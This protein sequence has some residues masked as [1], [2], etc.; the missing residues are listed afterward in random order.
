MAFNLSPPDMS[1]RPDWGWKIGL[2][3]DSLD[4]LAE[5]SQAI[6]D[7][8]ITSVFQYS[9]STPSFEIVHGVEREKPDLLFVELARASKPAAE[10]IADVRRGGDS[11]LII[12]VHTVPE[13]AEMISALRAGASEFVCLP[14]KP[15][16]FEALDRIGTLLEA[17]RTATVEPGKIAGVLSPK[18]G[19]GATSFACY[20]SV[21]LQMAAPASR[22]LVADLDYQ[23]PDSHR[24]FRVGTKPDSKRCSNAADALEQVRRV[25]ASSWREFVTAVAPNVDLLLSP[26][27]SSSSY[28]ETT[29]PEM[30]RVESLFRF[31]RRQYSWILTD[32]GRHLNPASWTVLQNIDDLYIVTA[33]DVLALYQTRSVLQTL[34]SR[35][36]EKNRIRI[37]LNRNLNGPRDFWVESI[38]QMFEIMVFGVIPSDY[39][40][41]EKA[42]GDRFAFPADTPFGKAISKIA[43]KILRPPGPQGGSSSRKAA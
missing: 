8:G 30:W 39:P 13:P 40:A 3:V 29:L 20:L 35:G 17:R 1:H 18:G 23:S 2:V 31:V 7:V 27:E 16:I 34:S 10:W 42:P 24:I 36:F 6:A 28:S 14:V 41:F 19:C 22:V 37:I 21:A 5:I 33:P 38:Q 12:A 32:L 4:L 43:A 11:P 26:A 25:G 15:S 9:A